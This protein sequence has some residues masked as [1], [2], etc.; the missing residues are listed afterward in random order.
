MM[1]DF[2]MPKDYFIFD[3]AEVS[4]GNYIFALLDKKN[5]D[6][7]IEE[8]YFVGKF[9]GS[10]KY[11][12]EVNWQITSICKGSRSGEIIASSTEGDILIISASEKSE[13]SLSNYYNG[14]ISVKTV[15]NV[16]GSVY[17]LSY[18]GVIF[19]R[20]GNNNWSFVE[21]EA[22][23]GDG[24]INSIAGLDEHTVYVVGLRG[25]VWR[26]REK[27]WNKIDFPYNGNLH[28]VY[29]SSDGEVYVCGDNGYL[30]IGSDEEW[31]TLETG[32]IVEDFWNVFQFGGKVFISSMN[33][34]FEFDGSVLRESEVMDLCGCGHYYN[35]HSS[36]SGILIVDER[37]VFNYFKGNCRS[38]LK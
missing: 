30:A 13:E 2:D 21:L 3:G 22:K 29:C 24:W 8:T 32:G 11:L 18:G 34:I 7:A 6:N 28:D 36:D 31:Y 20:D 38:I 23:G 27:E 33:A 4:P 5:I 12:T 17:A 1:N 9:S 37:S 14:V 26:K 19:K 16:L 15:K 10:W 35:S 25:E